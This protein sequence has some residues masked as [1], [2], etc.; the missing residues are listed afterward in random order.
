MLPVVAETYDG[1]LND[2][3]GFHLQESD[4]I[5]AVM[6]ASFTNIQEGCV[7]G[8]TGMI[9]HGFKAGIG[10]SSRIATIGE[11][12]FT[13]GVL[14]QANCG[15]RRSLT[16]AGVRVGDKFQNTPL[17]GGKPDSDQGSI[18]V[19]VATDCPLL[20]HQLNR[21][22]RR[23]PGGIARVGAYG[24][25]SSGDIFLAFSTANTISCSKD[26]SNVKF[27]STLSLEMMDN[28]CIDPIFEAT[29]QATEEAMLNSLTV[30]ETMVGFGGNTAYK[31]PQDELMSLL[32]N[33]HCLQ[34]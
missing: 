27:S 9:A 25:N 23:V 33:H 6:N 5:D 21:V 3:N 10:T 31:L 32:K 28:E 1:V 26:A 30:A 14:V 8:G 22:A 2:I 4:A 12:Q 18:I 7:G 29:I 11:R 17:P 13:V 16:V 20:P 24:A 19:I 15:Y 34:S